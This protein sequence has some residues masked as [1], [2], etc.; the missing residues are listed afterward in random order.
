MEK[1]VVNLVRGGRRLSDYTLL[2]PVALATVG[3]TEILKNFIQKGG[4]RIWTLI[5]IVVGVLVTV[6]AFYLPE[7]ILYGVISVSGATIFYDTVYK[8]FQKLFAKLSDKIDNK[9]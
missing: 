3:L 8:S 5:T 1:Y 9:E 6:V 2:I 4:K 7:K